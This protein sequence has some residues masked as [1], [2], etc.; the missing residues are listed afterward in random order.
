MP[1]SKR[2]PSPAR[3]RSDL[4]AWRHRLPLLLPR[5]KPRDFPR[6]TFWRAS[7][8]A[9]RSPEEQDFRSSCS[10]IAGSSISEA[11]VFEKSS[12]KKKSLVRTRP[13][14]STIVLMVPSGR[15]E[16]IGLPSRERR[17]GT[18]LSLMDRHL[19]RLSER[20]E[21]SEAFDPLHAPR[22]VSTS[23]VQR[24]SDTTRA[25]RSPVCAAAAAG[26]HLH[27]SRRSE[28]SRQAA[29]DSCR[30]FRPRTYLRPHSSTRP[31]F[32]NRT[33]ERGGA[34]RRRAAVHLRA[35]GVSPPCEGTR[36]LDSGA[37]LL[38]RFEHET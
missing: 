32:D 2:D 17:L 1:A 18:C 8:R 7:E 13:V 22:R 35:R 20:R 29:M 23:R 38:M 10:E 4:Q 6:Q 34:A 25:E 14:A 16:R 5:P 21:R 19:P 9:R 27:C 11:S 24:K 31:S 26:K 36:R 30:R 33:H 15:R 37:E 3:L 12:S 28:G